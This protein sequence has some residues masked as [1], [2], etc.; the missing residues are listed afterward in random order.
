MISLIIG[1]RKIKINLSFIHQFS[2]IIAMWSSLL[3]GN[4]TYSI[5]FT[6]MLIKHHGHDILDID[7]GRG[8]PSIIVTFVQRVQVD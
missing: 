5:K 4:Q 3:K 1:L 7:P 2:P 8:K 6:L